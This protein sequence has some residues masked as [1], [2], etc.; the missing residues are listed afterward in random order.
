MSQSDYVF[1]S[2][3]RTKSVTGGMYELGYDRNKFAKRFNDATEELHGRRKPKVRRRQ[4]DS[5][6]FII[7]L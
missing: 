7:G 5:T 6:A 2:I 4:V 1:E 3:L